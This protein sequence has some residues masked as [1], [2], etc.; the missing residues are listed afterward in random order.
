MIEITMTVIT[1]LLLFSTVVC[2]LWI[3]YSGKEVEASSL[4]F[5]MWIGILT[6]VSVV[7]TTI[8]LLL[9]K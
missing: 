4:D 5:H 6:A 1:F 3:R 2:G 7:A 9:R 8:I